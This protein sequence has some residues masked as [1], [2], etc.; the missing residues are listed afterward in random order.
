MS[1]PTTRVA[2]VRHFDAS[3]AGA[4]RRFAWLLWLPLLAAL[5]SLILLDRT[6]LDVVISSWFYDEATGTWPFL[7]A[8]PWRTIYFYGEIPA[9]AMGLAGLLLAVFGMASSR[10]APWRRCGVFLCLGVVVGPGVLVN[11]VLKPYVGRPRPAEIQQFGGAYE[12]R[13]VF[14]APLQRQGASFP[15]GHAAMGFALLIPAFVFLNRRR[16]WSN[17]LFWMGMS[18]GLLVGA[19]RIVQGRHFASDVLGAFAVVYATAIICYFAVRPDR[20][21]R[22]QQQAE[23]AGPSFPFSANATSLLRK[24]AAF[25]AGRPRTAAFVR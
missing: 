20:S 5:V 18:V 23:T 9:L 17:T 2:V 14:A 6:R 22:V 25:T 1:M 7:H 3:P 8:E 12:F 16:R 24:R 21:F 11:C 10:C 15:S 13:P 4:K 19:T